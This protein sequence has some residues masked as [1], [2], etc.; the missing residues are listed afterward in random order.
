L[1]IAVRRVL[2]LWPAASV[3]SVNAGGEERGETAGIILGM[4]CNGKACDSAACERHLTGVRTHIF[5]VLFCG[6]DC[7]SLPAEMYR[8]IAV[9]EE[10]L[11]L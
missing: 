11:L 8:E 7:S 9:E 3:H 10:N 5:K 1:K 6:G 2:R 4:Q